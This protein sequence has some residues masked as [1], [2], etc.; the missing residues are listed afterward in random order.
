MLKINASSANSFALHFNPFGK[1][2]MYIRK[3]KGAKVY[4]WGTPAKFF[5]LK[6]LFE[7]WLKDNFQIIYKIYL[8]FPLALRV[9]LTQKPLINLRKLI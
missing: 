4:P 1:S 2:L 5:H 9:K 6:Q 3:R 8:R 7:I